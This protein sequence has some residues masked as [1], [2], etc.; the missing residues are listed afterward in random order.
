MSHFIVVALTIAYIVSSAFIERME[1]E[2]RVMAADFV[3]LALIVLAGY[4]A[5]F[6]GRL[7]LPMIH[8][9]VLPLFLVFLLGAAFAAHPDRAGTELL[10]LLFCFVGSIAIVNLLADL[11]EQ[12]LARFASAY[13]IAM[14]LLAIVCLID[15]LV[16]PGLI[17]SR[18][19]GGLQGPF[20]NTGQAG[21][22]FLVHFSIALA[23]IVGRVVQ[24]NAIH[25]VGVALLFLALIFTLKRASIAAVIVGAV[26][27][28]ILMFLSPSAKNKRIGLGFIAV[29]GAF[30]ALSWVIFTWALE[31]IPE[32]RWRLDRKYSAD[33]LDKFSE[34]F[35]AENVKSTLAALS[36]NPWVGVGL[37]NVQGVYQSYEIHS[38]YLGVLAYGGLLGVLA[39]VGFI[40]YL[41]RSMIVAAKHGAT[42]TWA[43]FL[44]MLIP[45]FV[46]LLVAW[47]YTYHIRKRE[48]WILMIFVALAI[49]MSRTL[50][51]NR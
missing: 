47:S 19:I 45:L 12:W 40:F 17:S 51:G 43:A 2:S 29:G 32:L 20:S 41:F 49:R 46:G 37:G 5:V 33:T 48:F 7:V 9:A 24:R 22:F 18:A 36:H 35:L 27:F 30:S 25:V 1:G 34:G 4:A 15:F 8:M 44:Y 28:I 39:Y 50:R 42:T 14:G 21:S 31:T 3:L 10:I 11:P 16:M 6:R 38:T 13:V 26:A 23:L